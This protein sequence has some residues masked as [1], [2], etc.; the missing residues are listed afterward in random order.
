MSTEGVR[1]PTHRP[2]RPAARQNS[3]WVARGFTIIEL[4]VTLTVFAVLVSLAVPSFTRMML[5]DRITAQTNEL[6][7]GLNAAKSEAIR[8]GQPVSLRARDD[9]NPNDFHRGWSSFT[10]ANADGVA[11]APATPEDGT[12]MRDTLAAAGRTTVERVT[13]AGTSPAFTY[14]A[15]T[16]S[17]GGRQ[18][19]TFNPRGRITGNGPAFFRVCDASNNSVPGRIIQ[20]SVVGRVSLENTTL[21]CP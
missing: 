13:R 19:V 18:F 8:L 17:L 20:V 10:D 9:A 15:A 14:D 6:V 21:A 7:M 3:I 1:N 11:E 16:S 12:V 4:M 5:A 2:V